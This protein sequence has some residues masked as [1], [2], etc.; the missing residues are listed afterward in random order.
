MDL[1]SWSI[2]T[3][4]RAV[5]SPSRWAAGGFQIISQVDT[6]FDTHAS[7]MRWHLSDLCGFNALSNISRWK[8]RA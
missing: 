6:N 5:A 2:G 4:L 8:R 3:L 7:S 1:P